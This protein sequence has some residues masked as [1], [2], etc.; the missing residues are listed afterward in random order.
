MSSEA[1]V[2]F[3]TIWNLHLA[4]F[5]GIT[6]VLQRTLNKAQLRLW[7]LEF[8]LYLFLIL[9]FLISTV[10]SFFAP[11]QTVS[12][13]VFLVAPLEAVQ[14]PKLPKPVPQYEPLFEP[15][16]ALL[17]II[18]LLGIFR[19]LLVLT[20]R[21][22]ATCR[23]RTHSI[24]FT[25]QLPKLLPNLPYNLEVFLTEQTSQPSA[26]GWRQ[27]TIFLPQTA[28]EQLD[29]PAKDAVIY[30]ELI[31]IQERHWPKQMVE[32]VI[33]ALFWLHP[34]LRWLI[35]EIRL[36]R[37]QL[38]DAAVVQITGD[39]EQYLKVLSFFAQAKHASFNTVA[40][41]FLSRP[42]KMRRRFDHLRK[43]ESMTR[44]TRFDKFQTSFCLVALMLAGISLHA[45]SPVFAAEP[46]RLPK[47]SVVLNT[48]DIKL[49]GDPVL[50]FVNQP[51]PG[52]VTVEITIDSRGNVSDAKVLDGLETLRS[53]VLKTTLNLHFA[54]EHTPPVPVVATFY[55]GS[56]SQLPDSM[57]VIVRP[58]LPAPPPPPEHLQIE[59]ISFKGV[60]D[61]VQMEVRKHITM[62][63]GDMFTNDS[64]QVMLRQIHDIDK[65]LTISW[66]IGSAPSTTKITI[67]P[68]S[69]LLP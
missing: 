3:F 62:E 53:A 47:T 58:P 42:S 28:M 50:R 14:S 45:I 2:H 8:C 46:E 63:V 26:F 34:V 59:S 9:P 51:E 19:S 6:L 32:E 66:Q 17:L 16:S 61:P 35:A 68:R 7:L 44:I 21:Y 37:E 18:Y 25:G 49:V 13:L 29:S 54:V 41:T 12:S 30:H 15:V 20:L 22:R 39:R 60:P 24:R 67:G 36:C 27:P 48:Q 10:S 1:I 23:F 65:S 57:P 4:V 33:L 55:I 38:V 31:H 52:I 64:R 56:P 43:E 40:L 5:A 69:I 11:Q